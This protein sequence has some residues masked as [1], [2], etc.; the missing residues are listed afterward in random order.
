MSVI[1]ERQHHCLLG[2]KTPAFR[3]SLGN[4]YFGPL[5]GGTDDGERAALDLTNGNDE[6]DQGHHQKHGKECELDDGTPAFGVVVLS[7]CWW[8]T[9]N[10]QSRTDASLEAPPCF[11]AG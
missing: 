3:I 11:T 5:I 7:A 6:V 1:G 8:S 2:G 4:E 9:W 10:A